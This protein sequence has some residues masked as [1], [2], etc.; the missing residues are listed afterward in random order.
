MRQRLVIHI[1]LHKTGTTYYQRSVWPGWSGVDYAGKPRP[2]GAVSLEAVVRDMTG[3]VILLSDETLGGSL[4]RSYLDGTRW[5]ELQHSELGALK[6]RYAEDYDIAVLV[7]L[8]R[9]DA[10]I[11]SI[12]KHYLKYGGVE[13]LE[14]FLG[15]ETTPATIPATDMAFMGKVARVEEILGVRPFCF[16]LEET[17]LQPQRLSEQLAQF[18]GVTSGPDF[19]RQSLFNEGVNSREA[20]L[21]RW[22]NRLSVNPGRRGSAALSR[23]HT[24][25]FTVAR[26]LRDLGLLGG[27][28][29]G[30]EAT[31]TVAEY[32]KHQF[33]PDLNASIDY[34]CQ[35][36]G[37]EPS[38][39][40]DEMQLQL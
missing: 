19:T 16:F 5:P 34:L 6:D 8:R 38:A 1:G 14:D 29:A 32:V 35:G 37:L 23:N 39:F 9:H 3:P 27:D 36:R 17:R 2:K 40:R 15:L 33:E 12:Y 24:R 31:N 20:S 22:F 18:L 4:K 26:K 30:L 7:S 13:T 25:G 21:C 11:L 10:W 28:G